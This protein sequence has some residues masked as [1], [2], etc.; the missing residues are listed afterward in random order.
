M[1]PNIQDLPLFHFGSSTDW[2]AIQYNAMMVSACVVLWHW[3]TNTAAAAGAAVI[4]I[5]STPQVSSGRTGC[6]RP[7][8]M[9]SRQPAHPVASHLQDTV[10][11]V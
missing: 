11:E 2:F 7:W 10:S 3:L 8:T 4:P 1:C 5:Q 9:P 6:S